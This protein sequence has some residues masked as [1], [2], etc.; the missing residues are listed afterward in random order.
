MTDGRDRRLA[1]AIPPITDPGE[2]DPA[3]SDELALLIRSE[4]DTDAHAS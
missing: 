4:L 1:F 3:D 2:F